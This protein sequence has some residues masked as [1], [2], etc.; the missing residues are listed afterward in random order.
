[1]TDRVPAGR[2][3]DTTLTDGLPPEAEVVRTYYPRAW[4]EKARAETDGTVATATKKKTFPPEG[5]L[6]RA[7]W[8]VRVPVGDDVWLAPRFAWVARKIAS[9]HSIDAVFA[10]SS[11]YSALVFGATARRALGGVPLCLDLRDPWSM[12]FLQMRKPPWV[13]RVERSLEER[14]LLSADRVTLT[15]ESAAEAYRRA[16]DLPPERVRCIYNSFDPEHRPA[17]PRE[18]TGPVTLVHFGNVYGERRLDTVLR[19]VARLRERRGVAPDALRIVNL[20]RVAEDDVALAGELGVGGFLEARPVVPYK[21]GL[22]VLAGA[23]LQILLGYGEETLFVPAK[24]Y[25]YFVSGSPILCVAP[26]GSELSGIVERTGAGRS[27]DPADVEGTAGAI[28]AAIDA[29]AGGP[30]IAHRDEDAIAR[31]SAPRT[32]EELAKLLDE[33]CDER[34]R[35]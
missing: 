25:D 20:G 1:M 27:V 31:F 11:P 10:T 28:A 17:P 2:R 15:C 21:E 6:E 7:A 35:A 16:Y 32:A 9:Q 5:L 8:Q 33:M 13:R 24:L 29:R 23:D 34:A 14:L 4:K 19:A 26:A 12:N 3:V 18:R 22:E 30:P